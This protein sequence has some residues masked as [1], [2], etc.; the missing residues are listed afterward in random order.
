MTRAPPAPESAVHLDAV[1][2]LHYG[3]TNIR[4]DLQ[5]AERPDIN[6][7]R[8]AWTVTEGARPGGRTGAWLMS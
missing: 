7:M 1:D 4:P 2:P 8:A 6:A 5:V 3:L